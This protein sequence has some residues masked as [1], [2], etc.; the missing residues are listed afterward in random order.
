M[1]KLVNLLHV[2]NIMRNLIYVSKFSKDNHVYFEFHPNMC[3][4]TSQA[5]NHVLFERFLDESLLYFFNNLTME[6]LRCKLSP[7]PMVL[8]PIVSNVVASNKKSPSDQ[9]GEIND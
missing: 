5:S 2:Q 9:V 7:R 3:F 8:S 4:G 1:L 6:S